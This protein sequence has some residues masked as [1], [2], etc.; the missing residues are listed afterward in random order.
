MEEDILEMARNNFEKY[1]INAKLIHGDI[2]KP[3]NM[4]Q[5]DFITCLN[6]TLGYIPE[7]EKAIK[8]MKALGKKVILEK[9]GVVN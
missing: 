3:P 7:E 4:N 8:N 5:F 6:N 2:T 1:G 9:I